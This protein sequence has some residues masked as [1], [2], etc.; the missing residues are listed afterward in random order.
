MEFEGRKVLFK[1]LVGSH[2]YNLNT[3]QSDKDYKV[4]ICPTFDDLFFRKQF[5]GSYVGEVDYGVHDIR[6]VSELWWKANVNFLEVLFSVEVII[7]YGLKKETIDLIFEVFSYKEELTKMNLPYLYDA[8]MG[9]FFNKR[10]LVDKG[11]A[12]TKH[13]LDKYGYDTKQASQSVRILDFLCRY[14]KNNFEDFR[15]AIRYDNND[16]MRDFILDLRNGK[17]TRDEY[18]E[19]TNKLI[20]KV[21]DLK[22]IYKEHTLNTE[23][24]EKLINCIKEIVKLELN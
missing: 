15:Q 18:E 8:S 23:T 24:K 9:M 2:N 6:H 3:P 22:P 10:K 4:F 5:S 20:R 19:H 7:N 14:K 11:T 16:D 12:E 1:T 17:Y 13:L 21:E